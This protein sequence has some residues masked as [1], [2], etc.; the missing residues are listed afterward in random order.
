MNEKRMMRISPLYETMYNDLVTVPFYKTNDGYQYASFV[1]GSE[2][3]KATVTQFLEDPKKYGPQ[4]PD[5]EEAAIAALFRDVIGELS[6]IKVSDEALTAWVT[7]QKKQ[8][9]VLKYHQALE[10]LREEIALITFEFSVKAQDAK[11]PVP[12]T[13]TEGELEHAV[14]EC[15]YWGEKVCFTDR[16]SVWEKSR[17]EEA[18]SDIVLNHNNP[19]ADI[20]IKE[21]QFIYGSIMGQFETLHLSTSLSLTKVPKDT[22]RSYMV[23]QPGFKIKKAK[24]IGENKKQSVLFDDTLTTEIAQKDNNV[25]VYLN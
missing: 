13:E 21:Q 1:L 19:F 20:S 16:L 15:Q 11:S 5:G 22:E 7:F 2:D 17:E 25:Y 10:R 18:S 23:L 3:N 4:E 6:R 8:D 24:T 14:M 12:K 9:G